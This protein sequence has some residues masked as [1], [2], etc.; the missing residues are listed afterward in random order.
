MK[1][2]ENSPHNPWFNLREHYSRQC[3]RVTDNPSSKE[4]IF[5]NE[6]NAQQRYEGADSGHESESRDN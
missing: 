4:D 3:S 6:F 1:E 2:P 5:S